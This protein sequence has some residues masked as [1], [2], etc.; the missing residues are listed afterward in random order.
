MNR[1]AASAHADFARALPLLAGEARPVGRVDDPATPPL[2]AT[3]VVC[4]SL[5]LGARLVGRYDGVVGDV[6]GGVHALTGGAF[7][8]AF[9]LGAFAL[10]GAPSDACIAAS[11]SGAAAFA[12][13][14]SGTTIVSPESA[15]C[16]ASARRS[17]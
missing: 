7:F 1:T 4:A 3:A 16:T 10:A 2:R 15:A 5:R 8:A 17:A 14:T 13:A 9:A 12:T 6:G 11:R